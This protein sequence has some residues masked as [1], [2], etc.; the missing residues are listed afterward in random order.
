MANRVMLDNIE[1]Q[2]LKVA[3]KYGPEFGDNVNQVLVFPTEYAE[4]QR[5]YPILFRKDANGDYV[6]VAIL[7]LDKDEN[8]FLDGS[9]WR[10]RYVPAMQARGPFLIGIP[11]DGAG[12]NAQADPKVNIDLD[13]PRVGETQGE[14]LFLPHGGNTPY[15]ERMARVLHQIHQ[16]IALSRQMFAAF[17]TAGLIEP[18][19]VEVALGDG[20]K[21]A[22]SDCF[23]ISRE[24]LGALDGAALEALNKDG[25]LHLAY[26]AASS[27]GNVSQLV[28][29]KERKRANVT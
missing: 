25:F 7:G 10:A 20:A 21:Y 26:M 6:S 12:D 18:V 4:I 23:T 16:G 19:T 28:E 22:V 17:E 14:P 8:L 1:H 3:P 5:E 13:D 15:L 27:L 2:K 11:K 29:L 9:E 24:R